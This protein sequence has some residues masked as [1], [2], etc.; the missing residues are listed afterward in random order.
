MT[1][2]DTQELL[3]DKKPMD[4]WG[5][6]DYGGQTLLQFIRGLKGALSLVFHLKMRN[7]EIHIEEIMIRA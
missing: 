7:G 6:P 4:L 1:V 5:R 2:S 3:Y